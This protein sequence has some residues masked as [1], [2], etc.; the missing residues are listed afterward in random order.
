LEKSEKEK[1]KVQVI[2]SNDKLDILYPIQHIY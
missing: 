1:K 2:I